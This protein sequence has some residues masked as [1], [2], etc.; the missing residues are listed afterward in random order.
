MAIVLP[1]PSREEAGRLLADLLAPLCP[2][3]D[4]LIL[5]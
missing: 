2:E 4:L 3:D 5:A 1:L